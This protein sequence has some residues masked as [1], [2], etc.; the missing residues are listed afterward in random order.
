MLISRI[1][2]LNQ[3]EKTYKKN[4]SRLCIG[5]PI[6]AEFWPIYGFSVSCFRGGGGCAF[7]LRIGHWILKSNACAKS[8]CRA[9]MLSLFLG[10][11]VGGCE[12]EHELGGW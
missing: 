12:T 7:R 4:V 1:C 6:K 2:E 3:K 5:C 10:P 11:V 9:R 8:G